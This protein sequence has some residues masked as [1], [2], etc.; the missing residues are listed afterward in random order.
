MRV[1]SL[2]GLILSLVVVTGCSSRYPVRA[3]EAAQVDATLLAVRSSLDQNTPSV[4][5][6][7]HEREHISEDFATFHIR[8]FGGD[9]RD[10]AD[11]SRA[12]KNGLD[13]LREHGGGTL[14]LSGYNSVA[15]SATS[16]MPH[17][18]RGRTYLIS[19]PILIDQSNIT[20][21][22]DNPRAPAS[23][24]FMDGAMQGSILDCIEIRGTADKPIESIRVSNLV[25]NGNYLKQPGSYNPRAIDVDH[26]HR[27][28]LED[29]VVTD[30]FVGITFGLG[31]HYSVARNIVI[32]R[33]VDDAFNASGDGISG[34]CSHI[35]FERCVAVGS[36]NEV[37][38][39]IP[40]TRNNAWE[41][42]DGASEI[43]LTDCRVEMAGGNGFA[44]RNHYAD[45]GVVTTG[46]VIFS[47]CIA[48][49][50]AGNG[51]YITAGGP[52][53]RIVDIRLTNCSAKA[54]ARFDKGIEGISITNCMFSNAVVLG[55]ARN[56]EISSTRFEH[57]TIWAHDMPTVSGAGPS[58]ITLD[59]C[60]IH[61]PLS[62]FGPEERVNHVNTWN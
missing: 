41:I 8:D 14:L 22:S 10:S 60:S 4:R 31:A 3:L 25:L 40:G 16:R 50:V 33:W 19:E 17:S 18:I 7:L 2:F 56:A 23:I 5:D 58:S 62:V 35:R 55:P 45:G 44:V 36:L 30:V 11:D 43:A 57:L 13:A 28:T 12:F 46:P 59:S 52:K 34:G 20:I 61:W 15:Q 9:P 38:G 39:G 32:T 48:S 42:E 1:M 26:A 53:N 24:K 49:Y 29:L 47:S 6:L 27:V 51:F 21:R 54:S 37:N